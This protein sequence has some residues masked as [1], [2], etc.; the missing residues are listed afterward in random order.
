[1]FAKVEPLPEPSMARHE[2]HGN[3][4]VG[5]RCPVCSPNRYATYVARHREG[6]TQL[7]YPPEGILS[8]RHKREGW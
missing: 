5:I 3:H 6:L 1:M 4:G 7:G 2:N 8:G